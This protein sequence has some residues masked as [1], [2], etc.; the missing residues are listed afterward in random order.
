VELRALAKDEMGD[1]CQTLRVADV[2]VR[3][4]AMAVIVNA[5]RAVEI[6]EAL[7]I[8]GCEEAN[9]PRKVVQACATRDAT[10]RASTPW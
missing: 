10:D 7:R 9:V 4:D 5:V 3:D 1:Q 8:V 2:G 6:G